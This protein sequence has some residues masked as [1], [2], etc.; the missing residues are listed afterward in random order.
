MNV[1]R[2]I[3]YRVTVENRATDSVQFILNTVPTINSI[4]AVLETLGRDTV[5]DPVKWA[6]RYQD[7]IKV[8]QLVVDFKVQMGGWFEKT[9]VMVAG[10]EVG[11]IGIR[12]EEAWTVV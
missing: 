9:C 4:V 7:L 2:T 3:N 10:V 12:S 8:A 5:G 6:K 11:S 1:N